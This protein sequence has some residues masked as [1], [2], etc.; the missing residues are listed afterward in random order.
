[1]TAI[2]SS[3]PAR[4][5]VLEGGRHIGPVHEVA[6]VLG[7]RAEHVADHPR[8]DRARDLGDEIDLL[9][10]GHAVEDR[11]DDRTDVRL[12][13][14]DPL[15]VERLAHQLLEA[16]VARRVHRDHLQALHVKRRADVVEQEDSAALGGVRL[17]VARDRVHI[18]VARDRPEAALLRVLALRTP[19]HGSLPA[20]PSE[21]LVGR[22]GVPELG[23]GEVELGEVDLAGG[24]GGGHGAPPAISVASVRLST[25]PKH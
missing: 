2:V 7:R 12:V 11:G 10:V 14:G 8:G 25:I 9:A 24:Q 23:I 19:V 18:G 16:V 22:L 3:Q 1:M 6:V 5:S 21:Q 17:E 20:Q 13:V 4:I 15:G